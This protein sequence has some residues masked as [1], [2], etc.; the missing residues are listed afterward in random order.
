MYRLHN[1]S[2]T[3]S[4]F[5]TA[6]AVGAGRDIQKRSRADHHGARTYR[7]P[8]SPVLHTTT[9]PPHPR[10]PGIIITVENE[11]YKHGV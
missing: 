7:M 4:G 11:L 10:A 6:D 3:E 8:R 2:I 1:G 9:T 5:N